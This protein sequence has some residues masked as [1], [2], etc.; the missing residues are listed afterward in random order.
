MEFKKI[1]EK[2]KGVNTDKI[3]NNKNEDVINVTPVD[4]DVPKVIFKNIILEV[5]IGQWLGIFSSLVGRGNS[6]F[7]IYTHLAAE[8]LMEFLS[9][10]SKDLDIVALKFGALLKSI[11][12]DS[13]ET[14]VLGDFDKDKFTF[15]CHFDNSG[16]DVSMKASWGDG[17]DFG[18]ELTIESEK[19][20][21]TYDYISEYKERPASLHL[22]HSTIKNPDNDSSCYRFMSPYS[23]SLS[24]SNGSHNLELNISRPNYNVDDPRRDE[25]FVLKNEDELRQYLLGLSFPINIGEVYKD[26]CRISIDSVRSFPKFKL[27]VKEKTDKD[28]EKITDMVSLSYGNLEK[29]V[30]T[31]DGRTIG[32]DGDDNWSYGL[33]NLSLSQQDGAVSYSLSAVP[34]KEFLAVASPFEQLDKANKEVNQAKVYVKSILGNN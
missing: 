18:P 4:L 26:I 33:G 21:K 15:K 29:F 14:C 24:L 27:I 2:I 12:V 28:K 32:L 16:E 5:T 30:M 25:D 34:Q 22:Q 20:S 6:E 7:K 8:E 13:S 1:I 11:G 3:D 10:S 23:L 17:I 31:K 9:P 19:E